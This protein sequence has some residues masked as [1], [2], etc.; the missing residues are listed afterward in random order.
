MND[1]LIAK[2]E[3]M[4]E[5][6]LPSDYRHFLLSHTQPLLETDLVFSPPHS[7]IISELLTI[8]Q[9][10]ENSEKDR[11]GIPDMAL[12][13]IGGNLMGGSL[14]LKV[15]DRD[16]GQVH[17]REGNRPDIVLGSFTEFLNK[18]GPD[19]RDQQDG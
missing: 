2:L 7:G 8:E 16:F 6:R 4:L 3:S 12:L 19:N 13:H 9:I 17:Y 15:S 1:D 11:I 10:L 14:Y 18:S 5:C